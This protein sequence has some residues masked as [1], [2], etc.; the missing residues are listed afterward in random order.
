MPH[1]AINLDAKFAEF[2]DTWSP[3]VVARLNDYEI[4]LVHLNGEFVWHTHEDTDELFLVL[5][6]ELTIRLRAGDVMV[7]PGEMFV[8]P[9]GVEHCPV[10]SGEVRAM[11]IEPVGVVNTGDA[12]G[13][14][15][16]GYDDSLA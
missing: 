4:K 15:T 7:G 11:L 13:V 10:T 8:V 16:A 9:R 12:G 1:A 3:K 5:D 2:T 6:G 14:R